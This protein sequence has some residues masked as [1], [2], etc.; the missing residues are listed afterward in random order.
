MSQ[1]VLR[2]SSLSC[3]SPPRR[4]NLF[5]GWLGTENL[6][7]NVLSVVIGVSVMLLFRIFKL[8]LAEFW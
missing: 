6:A 1:Y 8:P 2:S 4:R 7:A 5:D 3:A